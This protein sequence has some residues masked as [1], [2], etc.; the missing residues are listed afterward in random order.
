MKKISQEDKIETTSTN[1]QGIPFGDNLFKNYKTNWGQ[2]IIFVLDNG[3]EVV[4]E[5]PHFYIKLDM[6]NRTIIG[7]GNGDVN[8]KNSEV[9]LYVDGGPNKCYEGYVIIHCV[10]EDGSTVWQLNGQWA[11]IHEKYGEL[12][13]GTS[14]EDVYEVLGNK[15][16]VYLLYELAASS[17]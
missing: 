17:I 12:P 6:I 10:N 9:E 3:G 7:V 15:E 5:H 16:D 4:N 14:D 2:Y 13:D 1:Q 11:E 8:L